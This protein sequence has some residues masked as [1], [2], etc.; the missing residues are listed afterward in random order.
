MKK[1]IGLQIVAANLN[2]RHFG[3]NDNSD[4]FFFRFIIR[5]DDSL[6]AQTISLKKNRVIYLRSWADF[7]F[8]ARM[9]WNFIENCLMTAKI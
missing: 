7:V 4:V 2:S 8:V 3:L 1:K 6:M 5:I 9:V